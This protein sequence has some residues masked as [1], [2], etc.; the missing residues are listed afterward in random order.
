MG[1]ILLGSIAQTVAPEAIASAVSEYLDDNPVSAD[2]PLL[3]QH[4]TDPT[5]HQ[6]YDDLANGR[7]V[8]HLQN[9]MA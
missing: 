3:L 2:E 9:G 1:K 6:V 4:L 5:P 7:F 8:S